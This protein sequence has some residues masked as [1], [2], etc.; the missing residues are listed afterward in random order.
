M[1][2]SELVISFFGFNAI[3]SALGVYEFIVVFK[4]S[5]KQLQRLENGESAL[6]IR[7]ELMKPLSPKKLAELENAAGI[8]LHDS[9][10]IGLGGRVVSAEQDLSPDQ[11]QELIKKMEEVPWVKYANP[12]NAVRLPEVRQANPF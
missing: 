7:G 1:K 5:D 10:P 3:K 4:P 2:L 11:M 12:N 6:K 9:R 8:P